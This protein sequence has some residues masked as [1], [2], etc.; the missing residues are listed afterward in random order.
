MQT[1]FTV[2]MP[3]ETAAKLE[4]KRGSIPRSKFISQLIENCPIA[5]EGQ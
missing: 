1:V 4:K 3:L 2:N 5:E